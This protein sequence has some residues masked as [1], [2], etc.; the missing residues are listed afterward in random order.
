MRRKVMIV[1][2]ANL[3]TG[4]GINKH[5]RYRLDCP[6]PSYECVCIVGVG[7]MG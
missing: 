1:Y 2:R 5:F 6:D 3:V 7:S 4:F